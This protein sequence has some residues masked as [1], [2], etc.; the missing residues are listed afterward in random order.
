MG[1]G[2]NIRLLKNIELFFVCDKYCHFKRAYC[3]LF[4]RC[5]KGLQMKMFQATVRPGGGCILQKLEVMATTAIE[6]K[7]NLE[8]EFGDGNVV[9]FPKEIR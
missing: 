8:M 7:N 3:L 9:Y 6:A 2:V 4:Q 5:Q 1:L